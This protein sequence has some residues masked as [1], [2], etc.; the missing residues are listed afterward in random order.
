MQRPRTE[1]HLEFL[2]EVSSRMKAERVKAGYTQLDF[3][4]MIGCSV[5]TYN[6]FECGSR[7]LPLYSFR[8]ACKV[9]RKSADFMLCRQRKKGVE[10][11]V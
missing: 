8:Q 5:T 11:A 2:S 4:K 1:P 6:A 9:L 3:A 7:T 10:D